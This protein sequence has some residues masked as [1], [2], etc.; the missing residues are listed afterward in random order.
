[1]KFDSDEIESL[2][3]ALAPCLEKAMDDKF[4]ALVASSHTPDVLS[5]EQAAQ[6]LGVDQQTIRREARS[7]RL[8]TLK[9]GRKYR[10]RRHDLL[11]VFEEPRA[12]PATF[13]FSKEQLAATP[14]N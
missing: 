8:P 2:A 3:A 1:M 7:G 12:K 4:A 9:V 11:N 13:P 14:C 10:F 5:T 6:F